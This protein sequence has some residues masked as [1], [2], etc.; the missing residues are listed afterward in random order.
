M[1]SCFLGVYFTLNHGSILCSPGIPSRLQYITLLHAQT[2]PNPLPNLA[3]QRALPAQHCICPV[4]SH[5]P[6]LRVR[7]QEPPR[8]LC[9][10]GTAER[11]PRP[12]SPRPASPPPRSPPR[13]LAPET[14]RLGGVETW[15]GCSFAGESRGR[16]EEMEISSYGFDTFRL[17]R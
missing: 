3:A 15:S 1:L 6:T 16:D 7:S 13:H 12:G 4:T 2:K 11:S 14:A 8:T 10:P 5:S 9:S 17:L